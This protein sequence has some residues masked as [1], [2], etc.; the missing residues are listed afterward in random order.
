M[1]PTKLKP[2]KYKFIYAWGKY[3]DSKAYYIQDQMDK[4]EADKAPVDAIYKGKDKVTKE[5]KWFTIENV[6][7]EGT[8]L[9]LKEFV[10]FMR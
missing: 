9:S 6:E 10:A 4:A 7:D 1:M 3:L 8:K 5:D 2:I